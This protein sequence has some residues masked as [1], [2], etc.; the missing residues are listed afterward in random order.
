MTD[1]PTKR[2]PRYIPWILPLGDFLTCALGWLV[3]NIV[4][5]FSLP[6]HYNIDFSHWFG[7]TMVLAG[8]FIVPL[9]M[10][11]IYAIA[12]DYNRKDFH[13]TSRLDHTL[14]I[15]TVS[16]VGTLGIFFTALLNDNVPE[17]M[18]NY[19]LIA[20]L[21]VMLSAPTI[22][23]RIIYISRQNR[24]V[25]RGSGLLPAVITGDFSSNPKQLKR[26]MATAN[27]NGLR[28]VAFN[29]TGPKAQL[30]EEFGIPAE[31]GDLAACCRKYEA[32]A[33]VLFDT[34][35]AHV[36]D[37]ALIRSIYS[38]GLPVLV[39]PTA[40]ILPGSPR[41][42]K[43]VRPEPL[44]N[45]FNTN[46][47]PAQDDLKRLADIGVSALALLALSP[48]LAAV[49]AAVKIT[50][51]GPAFYRQERIGKN[52]KP[53]KI[54]K[55]RTMRTDAEAMGPSLSSEN[56][57]RVTPIGRWLRK[58]RIDELPQFWNVLIGDMSLVGPRPER[59]YYI[60]K[61]VERQPAYVLLHQV[62]PGI[63]SWGMVKFGYAS[64]VD[65]MIERSA[66]DLLY[67]ENISLAIDIKILLHT[68]VTV[69]TGKGV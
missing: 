59:A 5:F 32:R 51:P 18:T 37:K 31:Y 28:I 11:A 27:Y 54:I 47:S 34:Y 22:A 44:I 66:Y 50:S 24:K 39:T 67:I 19:Q 64:T 25:N 16:M 17:R 55:F 36:L 40:Q 21:F 53:F 42:I 23:W 26:L 2:L 63:T 68:I 38:L 12:G 52:R 65:Q 33:V 49:A 7:S 43:S 61:I 6:W 45:I 58:Y 29:T 14:T 13:P 8:Q 30:P 46:L 60:S 9:V 35:I 48:L 62:R 56:D 20:V 57:S 69:L 10:V 3:F 1:R 15:L 41:R 4:R